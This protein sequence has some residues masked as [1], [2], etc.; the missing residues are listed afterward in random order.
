MG[1]DVT[2]T[3]PNKA[4]HAINHVRKDQNTF[5]YTADRTHVVNTLNHRP[6]RGGIRL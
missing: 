5:S 1:K 2:K 6:M 4:P 3:R